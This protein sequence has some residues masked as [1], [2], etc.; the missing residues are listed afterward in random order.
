M[1]TTNSWQDKRTQQIN[2]DRTHDRYDICFTNGPAVLDPV[3][4]SLYV[5]D[6]A[7][8]M[9][10]KVRPYPRK[11]ENNIMAGIKEVALISGPSSPPCMIHHNA[12]A[13]VF[14]TGG[15]T[16]NFFHEFNDGFIPLFVTVNSVFPNNE[17]FVLVV[18]DAPDWWVKK[19]AD[20]L[21]SFSKHPIIRLENDTATH[22]FP[23]ATVG[24]ITHGFVTISPS[25]IPGFKNYTHFRA[26]L[27]NAFGRNILLRPPPQVPQQPRLVVASRSGDG[28]RVILNQ[29]EVVQAAKDIGFEVIVFEPTA[30]TPL[31][32]AY[33]L[34]NSSHAMIGVHGAAL[35][36]Q[37]F[38]RPGSVLMQIVPIG[39]EGVSDYC[40]GSLAR[41]LN[42]DY[43]EYKIG[44]QESSLADKYGSDHM[45]LQ[46]PAA[47][48]AN[49]WSHKV[50][51]IYLKEQNVRLDMVRFRES[52]KDLYGKAKRLMATKG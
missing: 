47:L 22:C 27:E 18:T 52:L 36:H 1:P 44:V 51:D 19:Y 50:M 4:S 43:V 24:L 6:P 20:L 40:F 38:L 21:G 25:L 32:E 31:H 17:D 35:T 9:T 41:Q 42:L 7:H 3:S 34:M 48:Q 29:D 39:A 23:S 8:Q 46:N 15:Y 11:P 37:L 26:L 28:G 12:P 30:D 2:C 5:T 45:L 10:E 13:L 14:S 49:G 33:R 16:G